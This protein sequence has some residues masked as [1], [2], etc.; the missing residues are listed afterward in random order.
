VLRPQGILGY[1]EFTL[2][3]LFRLFRKPARALAQGGDA[4]KGAVG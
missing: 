4:S 1:R 3:W 2:G